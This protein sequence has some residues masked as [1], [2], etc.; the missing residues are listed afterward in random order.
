VDGER[1]AVVEVPGLDVLQGEVDLAAV[2]KRHVD[3]VVVA[4]RD[5]SRWPLRTP[6]W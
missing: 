4:A 3:A 2:G 6:R 1:V 5:V